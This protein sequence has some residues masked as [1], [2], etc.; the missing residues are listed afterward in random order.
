M[1]PILAP[2]SRGPRFDPLPLGGSGAPGSGGRG[3]RVRGRVVVGDAWALIHQNDMRHEFRDAIDIACNV[4][5]ERRRA[6]DNESAYWGRRKGF[7]WRSSN[8][9][10]GPRPSSS[11]LGGVCA[12]LSSA[13]TSSSTFTG[14]ERCRSP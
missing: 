7:L 4:Y 9:V 8:S 14:E 10:L 6:A 1:R 3:R 2:A 11:G 5:R 13:S 12:S